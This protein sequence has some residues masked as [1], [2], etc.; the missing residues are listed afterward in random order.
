M[1][2]VVSAT[3]LR[4][5]K[6]NE[7]DTVTSVLQNIAV[8]LATPRGSAV[9]YRDFG[10]SVNILDRPM[11]ITKMMMIAD[12]REAIEEWEPRVT[13]TNIDF[14][15]DISEPGKLMPTVEVEIDSE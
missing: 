7:T 9:L 1:S 5:L 11:P 12:I 4:H 6:L 14:S 15:E 3:D 10:I 13:I 2:Y 8:I